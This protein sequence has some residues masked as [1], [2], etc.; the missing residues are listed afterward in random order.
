[1]SVN[2]LLFTLFAGLS[3]STG[4][5]FSQRPPVTT[6]QII[7]RIVVVSIFLLGAFVFWLRMRKED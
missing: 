7:F 2:K 5:I 6:A 3:A 4:L 1:M